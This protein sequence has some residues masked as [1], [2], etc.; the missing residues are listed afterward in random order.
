MCEGKSIFE[1]KRTISF[2]VV[3]RIILKCLFLQ[4]HPLKFSEANSTSPVFSFI[5]IF[6]AYL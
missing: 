6:N 4:W 1:E 2:C 3:E 5:L